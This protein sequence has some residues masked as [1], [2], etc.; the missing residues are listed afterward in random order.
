[1]AERYLRVLAGLATDALERPITEALDNQDRAPVPDA[2][3]T[4]GKAS[5]VPQVKQVIDPKTGKMVD[6]PEGERY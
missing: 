2:G 5:T 1:M 3:D 4:R 6:L